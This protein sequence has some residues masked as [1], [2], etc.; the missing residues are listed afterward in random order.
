MVSTEHYLATAAGYRILEMGGNAIDAGVASGIAL[1]VVLPEFTSF[2][3]VAPIMIHH[4]ETKETV[5]ISGLGR[6]PKA[7]SIDYFRQHANGEL[8]VGIL[9]TVT[10]AA[11]DA[12]LTALK[13]YG[14]MTFAQVVTPALEL[15][16]QGFPAPASLRRLLARSADRLVHGAVKDWSLRSLQLKFI[17]I[18]G[19]LVRQARRVGGLLVQRD[20]ARTFRRMMEVERANASQGREAA[21]QAA[22]D[23][24]YQGEIAEEMVRFCQDQ[25]GLLTTEDLA[26]FQVK[27]EPP[28]V[29]NYRGI[30]IYTCG[31]WCQG[32]VTIETLHILEGYDLKGMGH[33]TADYL[34]TLIE[35]LDLAFADR[36]A[37]YG[38]P[39]FVDVP[40][41][42][43]LSKPYAAARGRA[44]DPRHA[45]GEMPPAGDPWAYQD[46]GVP[47]PVVAAPTPLVGRVEGDTSHICVVDR[48]GNAFSA[49]P[50]DGLRGSPVAP[51]LGFVISPRGS[52][53]WLDP[54]HPCALAP[55]KRPRLTPNPA[56]AFKDGRVWMPFGTCGGDVQCQS[57]VQLVL[58]MVDFGMDLQQAI[59][60]SRVSTWSFPNSFWPHAYLPGLVGVEGRIASQTVAQLERR[61]HRVEV[62]DEWTSRMGSLCAIR[63]DDAQG[64]LL[65]GA[66]L[67]RDGYAI[68][69]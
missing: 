21:I 32:P 31:P 37:Y 29:G 22:R 48:W 68:G 23:F 12:W 36:H 18:G 57:M 66:D 15:A 25:G 24:F 20:L 6:W 30:D 27:L 53:T 60:A 43:L 34:H 3:G 63:V 7:A 67:R 56:M 14:T 9:R 10:P 38:D 39:E 62:W 58:N 2:G 44:I 49:T 4:A 33:N 42:G 11:A 59:E 54:A 50:S 52:Q 8:P 46:T 28:A 35:A 45:H 19:R 17:R 51:G 65:A 13:L 1:N 16:E 64:T 5:T 26:T 69:R 47:A 61:G 55:G 40:L 41:A